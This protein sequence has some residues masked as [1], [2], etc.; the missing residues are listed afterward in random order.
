MYA[1]K[2]RSNIAAAEEQKVAAEEWE[3]NLKPKEKTYFRRRLEA[4]IAEKKAKIG[5]KAVKAF[6]KSKSFKATVAKAAAAKK[7]KEK[8]AAAAKKSTAAFNAYL[9]T[10]H[11]A[12]GERAALVKRHRMHLKAMADQSNHMVQLS[13][14]LTAYERSQL[15]AASKVD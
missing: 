4:L 8:Q 15:S 6:K 7:Y 12:Q 10:L 2:K 1:H 3:H 14:G 9:D 13:G 5:E 11:D